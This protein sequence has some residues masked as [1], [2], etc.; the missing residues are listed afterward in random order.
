MNFNTSLEELEVSHHPSSTV[1]IILN[2]MY[3]WILNGFSYTCMYMHTY[4]NENGES[5]PLVNID[6]SSSLSL[7]KPSHRQR[8][9]SLVYI[10]D[11]ASLA[12]LLQNV[13]DVSY[14]WK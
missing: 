5:T 2:H 14:D 13:T 4:L 11:P 10:A 6:S 7:S 12:L 8:D 1:C 3:A 9:T